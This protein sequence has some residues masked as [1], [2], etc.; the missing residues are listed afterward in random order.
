MSGAI[1][2]KS[3]HSSRAT[4]SYLLSNF[5]LLSFSMGLFILN[6]RLM[7]LQSLETDNELKPLLWYV[8]RM[9]RDHYRN[10]HSLITIFMFRCEPVQAINRFEKRGNVWVH[11][12][13][14]KAD[15]Q[16]NCHESVTLTTYSNVQGLFGDLELLVERWRSPIS[17]AIHAPKEDYAK[18]IKTIMFFR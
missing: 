3:D 15:S 1:T 11:S 18:A 12:F 9:T 8:H 2:C 4:K 5:F 10:F 7:S 14:F 17:I 13:A 6:M 16:F